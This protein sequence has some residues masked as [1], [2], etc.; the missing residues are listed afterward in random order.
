MYLA[1]LSDILYSF[2]HKQSMVLI[3]VGKMLKD[4]HKMVAQD[5]LRTRKKINLRFD[6]VDDLNKCLKQIKLL[7]SPTTQY[8]YHGTLSSIIS[9]Q[10][11]S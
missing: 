4:L 10:I 8:D 1:G 6:G 2:G 7:T 11:L 3:L 9:Y 5:A